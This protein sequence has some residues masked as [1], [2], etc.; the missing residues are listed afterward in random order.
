MIYAA[1]RGIFIAIGITP[2]AP[3]RER[4]V[5]IAFFGICAFVFAGVLLLGWWLLRSM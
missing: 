5:A 3:G 1:L 2:P 4:W